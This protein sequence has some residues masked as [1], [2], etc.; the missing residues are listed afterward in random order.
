MILSIYFKD[1]K[2]FIHGSMRSYDGDTCI[3]QESQ[4]TQSQQ[5]DRSL[6]MESL[7][8]SLGEFGIDILLEDLEGT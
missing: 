6:N 3:E 1:R 2:M 8:A 4:G 5:S 7:P